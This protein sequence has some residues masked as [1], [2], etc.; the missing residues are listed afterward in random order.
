MAELVK[1]CACGHANPATA[2]YCEACPLMLSGIRAI[3][4]DAPPPIEEPAAAQPA[5]P[6]AEADEIR[7]VLLQNQNVT[8][9]VKPGQ[10][11][12]AR[13][14]SLKPDVVV[15][16]VPEEDYISGQHARFLKHGPDWY[17]QHAGH[18]NFIEVDGVRVESDADEVAIRDGSLVR[19][20]KTEFVVRFPQA[21]EHE[22]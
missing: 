15:S 18:T 10:T 1:I 21:G 12:G 20:A 17:V 2:N 5:A 3:D 4:P 11:V 22:A 6:A 7:L 14:R 8:V 19:L 13:G 9:T 16:G